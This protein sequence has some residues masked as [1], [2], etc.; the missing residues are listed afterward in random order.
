MSSFSDCLS[1]N[2]NAIRFDSIQIAH[3]E[4]IKRKVED[5]YAEKGGECRWSQSAVDSIFTD[6]ETQDPALQ[7][8]QIT[9]RLWNVNTDSSPGRP[10]LINQTSK[11][12][13]LPSQQFN[14]S[15]NEQLSDKGEMRDQEDRD[16]ETLRYWTV[17]NSVQFN[18]GV[19]H[20]LQ[21]R[22]SLGALEDKMIKCKYTQLC[23]VIVRIAINFLPWLCET[24][25]KIIMTKSL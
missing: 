7:S 11:I 10:D 17:S 24:E 13:Y 6:G 20:L 15:Q 4:T 18:C 23:S 3:L 21:S 19:E 8:A 2:N 9:L 25:N 14:D 1:K 5:V 16:D 12:L 22:W